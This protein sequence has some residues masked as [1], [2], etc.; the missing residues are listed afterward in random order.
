MLFMFHL[1]KLLIPDRPESDVD[2][3]VGG[4]KTIKPGTTAN[5]K[6]NVPV[7]VDNHTVVG[8]VVE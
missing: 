7:T 3:T 2:A 8:T 4:Q 6:A 1:M 5:G